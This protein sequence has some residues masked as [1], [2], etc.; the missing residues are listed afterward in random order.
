MDKLQALADL[1]QAI[2]LDNI[3]RELVTAGGLARWVARGLRGITS[4]PT[5]FEKAITGSAAYDG[6]IEALAGLDYSSVE[7]YEA[8]ALEDIGGAADLLRPVYDRTAGLDGYVSLEV[9]PAL[10]HDTER[11]VSEARRL[12]GLLGRPNIMIKVPATPAGRPAI[13]TLIGEGINVN[14]TL[15]FALAQ[16]DAVAR[17]YLSGLERLVAGGG[18]PARVASVASFFVSRV[19]SAVDRALAEIGEE[20]LQGKAAI[21]N[22]KAAYAHFEVVFRGERWE[23]L[24]RAGARVQRPLWA[25]TSTKNPRYPD[26]LYVDE[27]IGP[28]TVNTLPPATLEALIDHGRVAVTL[29]ADVPAAMDHLGH[30][31]ELGIDLDAITASLLDE[32]VAAFAASFEGLIAGVGEKARRLRRPRRW[33]QAELGGYEQPVASARDRMARERVVER[34]WAHDHTVWKGEPGGIA[35][36]LGWLHAPEA[37]TAKVDEM[38]SLARAVRADGYTD[39]LLLGMGG[40]SLAPEVL[41]RTLGV[42]EDRDGRY[43]DLAVLDS[44]APETVLAHA[45]RLDPRRTLLVVATKSGGTVETLSFFKFFYRWLV[46]AVGADQA[47]RQ[48]VAITDPGSQLAELAKEHRFRATF[49][50]DP[51]IGGRYSALSAFGLLPAAL[52]GVDVRE[53]LRRGQAM[54]GRCRPGG[55]G[56]E[57]INPG[58][59]LG[60]ILGALAEAGRDKVTLIAP[61]AIASFGA[62]VEQLVAESTGKEGK[63]ILPVVDEPLV[64]PETLGDDRLFIQLRLDGDGA[65]DEAVAGLRAAGHPVVTLSL[66]DRT[67]LGG[68]FFLWEMATAVAGHLLGIN[69]FDQPNVEAAKVLARQMVAAYQETGRLP[70]PDPSFEVGGIGVYG[71]QG[72]ASLSEVWDRF[73]GRAA[74]GGYIAIQAFLPPSASLGERLSGLAL[75]LRR[76][77]RLATTWGYGPRFLHSTGQL[78]KGDGGNGLF[79]QLTADSSAEAPI[80]DRPGAAESSMTFGVLLAAQALGDRQALLDAGRQVVRLHLG[81]EIE[82]GVQRLTGALD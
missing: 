36:R 56:D 61:D 29:T 5:I 49:L 11:T 21:A 53:L 44:T 28:Q 16:Y 20:S 27:L 37:M 39:V 47:G 69:P 19:D 70:A 82:R 1:G 32:G 62:W 4:N 79:I 73:L 42:G 66:R 38:V 10:A 75:A 50:N 34:I 22:A 12:F 40:S 68:Q 63:G 17:A 77:T 78:H 24:A 80:P 71:D 13:E 33:L 35:N 59:E 72:G 9:D 65:H 60:A 14:A 76:R 25:S 45:N 41:R 15:I 52:M 46:D 64:D 57:A 67:D 26:T 48:F 7:I 2:W 43:P 23:R 30:L 54:A 81:R 31:G 55:E 8:L 58:L 3:E 51:E 6:Q 18:D 74:A